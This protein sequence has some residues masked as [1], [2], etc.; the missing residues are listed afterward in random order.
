MR[1]LPTVIYRVITPNVIHDTEITRAHLSDRKGP[2]AISPVPSLPPF[3]VLL[4]RIRGLL[5]ARLLSARDDKNS[6]TGYKQAD[7]TSG[8]AAPSRPVC[9]EHVYEC[10]RLLA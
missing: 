5:R 10:R 4:T 9:I 8:W 1:E 2:R 7:C 6:V 3:S